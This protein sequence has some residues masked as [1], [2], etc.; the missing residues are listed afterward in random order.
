[1][2]WMFMFMFVFVFRIACA[3]VDIVYHWIRQHGRLDPIPVS[4][5]TPR[6]SDPVGRLVIERNVI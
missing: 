4:G 5:L 6:M 3:C 2:E 1:M